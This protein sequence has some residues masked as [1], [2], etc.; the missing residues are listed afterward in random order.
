M[1]ASPI[2]FA[3]MARR[4]GTA[5][6]ALALL[7]D[8]TLARAQTMIGVGLDYA[9]PVHSNANSG[10]GFELR[11]GRQFRLPPIVALTPELAYTY[12]DFSPEPVAYRGLVGLRLGLGEI[13]RPGVFGHVGIARLI[14]QSPAASFT[15]W[16]YD[17]GAFL[18]FTLVPAVNFGAHTAYNRVALPGVDPSLAWVTLGLHCELLF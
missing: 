18:D 4:C 2:R 3:G 7:V 15:D 17:A 11:L 14:Q 10:A 1:T 13:L 9:M 6:T 5:A 8:V 12:H 16:S